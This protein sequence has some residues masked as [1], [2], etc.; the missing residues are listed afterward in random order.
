MENKQLA[1][2]A[3]VMMIHN[4]KAYNHHKKTC[5][6]RE[7]TEHKAAYEA[8]HN[9][10]TQNG[11]NHEIMT[12]TATRENGKQIKIVDHIQFDTDCTLLEELSRNPA[13]VGQIQI[14]TTAGRINI[15]LSDN[16]NNKE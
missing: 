7:Y 8:L 4:M 15:E 2:N 5:H 11:Y 1:M 14:D 9:L 16:A 10:L 3:F 13:L 6:L 12:S